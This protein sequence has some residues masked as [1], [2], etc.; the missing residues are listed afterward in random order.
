MDVFMVDLTNVKCGVGDEVVLIGK[1]GNFELTP[2][3]YAKALDTS[4]YEILLKFKY[5]RMNK[6]LIK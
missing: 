6:V 2:N 4:A 1:S 5:D 3:H